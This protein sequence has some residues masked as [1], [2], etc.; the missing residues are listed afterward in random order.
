MKVVTETSPREPSAASATQV[1]TSMVSG[2]GVSSNEAA[3]AASLF[4][5]GVRRLTMAAAPQQV[6][7]IVYPADHRR[8]WTNVV[9][10]G[11]SRNG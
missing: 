1:I 8:A 11:S 6:A 3:M 9:S 5:S 4:F 2:G 7:N 10:Q